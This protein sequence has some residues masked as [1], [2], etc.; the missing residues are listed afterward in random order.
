VIR[1]HWGL[2]ARWF[3]EYA[4]M[5]A[6]YD[7]RGL[8]Y[9]AETGVRVMSDVKSRDGVLDATVGKVRA[10]P[11]FRLAP[12]HGLVPAGEVQPAPREVAA[13][14]PGSGALTIQ[15]QK[16]SNV[17]DA[18]N[19]VMVN[20]GGAVLSS[21]QIRLVFWG[22]EWASPAAPVSKSQVIAD[23]K[24]I[25]S[26]PYLDAA[27]QY[28]L[29]SAF[30]DRVVDLSGEDPPNPVTGGN[31]GNR[32]IKLI[33]DEVVPEPDEDFETAFYIVFLPS[34]VAGA[35]L[36]TPPG[37][38]GAHSYA[39]WSD[40]DFPADIDNDSVFYAWIGN[41]SRAGISA[42]VSHEL[43]E[44]MTDPTGNTWQVSPTNPTNWNEVGDVCQSTGVLN[45][46]TVQSYWSKSD[47]ACVIPYLTPDSYEVRWISKPSAIG[48]IEWFGGVRP[49]GSQW[50]MARNELMSRVQAGD[51]FTVHG[52]VSG[53]TST[54][55]IYYRGDVFHPYLGT[56]ADGVPDDNLLALPQQ[57]PH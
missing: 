25:V 43:I 7:L 49:D 12:G 56:S 27:K 55:G 44:A 40:F 18:A 47:N 57:Q 3:D 53:K 16:Y 22:T 30:V 15:H 31:V 1:R 34:Q 39:T 50:Q 42:T 52:P 46:V 19:Q 13:D 51:R 26:S 28:G 32:V 45:G 5:R 48:H 35:A 29:V 2:V 54:V 4:F 20:L 9:Q 24:G 17:G 11:P 23:V 33:D 14:E 38:N 36:S 41:Q 21:V 8:T 37:L 6:V 10:R